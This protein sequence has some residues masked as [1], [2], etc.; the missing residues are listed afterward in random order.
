MSTTHPT[1]IQEAA[2]ILA[3]ALVTKKRPDGEEYVSLRDNLPEDLSNRL[4]DV[5]FTA[6]GD[7]LPDDW[8]Y[9]LI[10]RVA[11]LM[12]D[13]EDVHDLSGEVMD[14]ADVYTSDLCD[15]LGSRT[16]RVGYVDEARESGLCGSDTDTGAMLGLGQ[17]MEL[18]EIYGLLLEA[19]EEWVDEA[20]EDDPETCPDCSDDV[21]YCSTCGRREEV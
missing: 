5:V 6:H 10:S 20:E 16:S 9:T 4:C 7:M 2:G 18:A 17:G 15:W 12:E 11:G 21:A 3:R 1:T 14:L 19:L 13:A 8:R